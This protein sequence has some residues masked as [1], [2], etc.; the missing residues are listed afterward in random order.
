MDINSCLEV[1]LSCSGLAFECGLAFEFEG[2][3]CG[4]D[5]V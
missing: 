2:M 1:C 5:L 3:E 4:V